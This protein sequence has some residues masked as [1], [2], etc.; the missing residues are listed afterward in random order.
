MGERL[1]NR[2]ALVTGST[3]NI[4]QAI[5]EALA[6]EGA[7]VVV[8]GRNRERGAQVVEGIRAS[9]GRADFVA[10]DLD[11]SAEAAQGLARRAR[12]ALGGRIDILVNNAGVYPAPGTTAT[13][14]K[15]FD[16]VYAI[17]V[18][19]P[20][21]LT[22]AVVPVMTESGGGVVINLG[23]WIARLGVP[24]GALYSST[25]GAMET[26]TRAWAAEFGPLGVRVNAIS[27]GVIQPPAPEGGEP[28]PGEIMMKGTPAGR[29]GTPDAIAHAAVWLASDEAAFVHGTVVDVDGGRT[30]VAVIAA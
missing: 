8:S 18:K 12:T 24:L 7:H 13:D 3:S 11:G 25:K 22:A 6:A 1:R 28:H 5:A 27:P 16:R 10:A 26:L 29:V 20:F 15:T 9:G 17:N 23:S 2:T 4:G 19:A 21:F 14:E 30:G